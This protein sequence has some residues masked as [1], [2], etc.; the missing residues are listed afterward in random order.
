MCWF[1]SHNVVIVAVAVIA[2]PNAKPRNITLIQVYG[3]ITAVTN[4]EMQM[5][6]KTCLEQLNKSPR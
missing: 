1:H 4:K 6:T 5:F 3:P 2:S